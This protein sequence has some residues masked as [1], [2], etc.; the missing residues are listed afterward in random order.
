LAKDDTIV[1]RCEEITLREIR[2]ALGGGVTDLNE[3]KRATRMGMGNCQGRMCGPALQEIIARECGVP[4][5][6]IG[7]LN[8]RPPIKPVPITALAGH[9]EFE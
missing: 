5:A 9:T 2:A 7:P 8:P 3:V 4:P 1:C 6:E